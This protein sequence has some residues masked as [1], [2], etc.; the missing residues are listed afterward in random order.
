[1]NKPQCSNCKWW[2]KKSWKPET[3]P[4]ACGCL[5]GVVEIVNGKTF[6]PVPE[7]LIYTPYDFLCQNH[8]PTEN[9]GQAK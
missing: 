6:K 3:D 1:M 5:P 2:L 4:V 9:S 8:K 7:F